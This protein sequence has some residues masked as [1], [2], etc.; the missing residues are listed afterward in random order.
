MLQ[1]C[2]FWV[3]APLA[4]DDI[5]DRYRN[6]YVLLVPLI[7][8]TKFKSCTGMLSWPTNWSRDLSKISVILILMSNRQVSLV[9]G[10][11]GIAVESKIKSNFTE[12][13]LLERQEWYRV[14]LISWIKYTYS[15]LLTYYSVSNEYLSKFGDLLTIIWSGKPDSR[16]LTHSEKNYGPSF[17]LFPL[18]AWTGSFKLSVTNTWLPVYLINEYSTLLL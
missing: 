17:L 7:K 4:W 11:M 10:N 14:C 8:G 13:Q 12:I 2:S 3:F 6:L 15:Y 16:I 1:L 9:L 5:W 18:I